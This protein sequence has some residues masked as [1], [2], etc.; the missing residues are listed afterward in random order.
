[1]NFLSLPENK[2][3]VENVAGLLFKTKRWITHLSQFYKK[4]WIVKLPFKKNNNLCDVVKGIHTSLM[5][6]AGESGQHTTYASSSS[7]I[8]SC[9]PCFCPSPNMSKVTSSRKLNASAVNKE[10]H[11]L[12]KGNSSLLHCTILLLCLRKHVFH[13]CICCR[14]VNVAASNQF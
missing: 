14:S 6:H 1:M 2:I 11:M 3:K 12:L 10:T 8:A 5:P 9:W 7:E 13:P 4:A